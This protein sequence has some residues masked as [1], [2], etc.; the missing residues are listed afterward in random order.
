VSQ[1]HLVRPIATLTGKLGDIAS[2][3]TLTP[4]SILAFREEIARAGMPVDLA[5]LPE[6]DAYAD[7]LER[8]A[9]ACAE[10]APKIRAEIE[11]LRRGRSS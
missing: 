9:S 10:V 4:Q 7:A 2:V 6:L 3:V 5:I 11:A 8:L 1:R